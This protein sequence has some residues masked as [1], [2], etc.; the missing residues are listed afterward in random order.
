[1]WVSECRAGT[2]PLYE[3][4]RVAATWGFCGLIPEAQTAGLWARVWTCVEKSSGDLN[5]ISGD[6]GRYTFKYRD[7]WWPDSINRLYVFGANAETGWRRG[8]EKRENGEGTT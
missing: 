1:M 4:N 8:I 6:N 5:A 7:S 2:A 3:T